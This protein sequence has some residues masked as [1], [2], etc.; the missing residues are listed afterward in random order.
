MKPSIDQYVIVHFRHGIKVE[1][2]VVSWSDTISVIKSPS[3]AKDIVIQDTKADILF[4]EV[5]R[6]KSEYDK[7]RDKPHK[8]QEDIRSLADLKSDLNDIER[9]EIRDKITSHEISEGTQISYDIPR[10]TSVPSVIKHPGTEAPRK[11]IGFSSGLS[12]LFGKRHKDH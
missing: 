3:G 7:I 4:Y 12:S 6:A 1:G 5:I 9:A 2:N 10:F 8:T 11:D